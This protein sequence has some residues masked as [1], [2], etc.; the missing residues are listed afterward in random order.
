[1][2]QDALDARANGGLS[3]CEIVLA[4]YVERLTA[5]EPINVDAIRHDGTL[6]ETFTITK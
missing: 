3:R 5:G 4:G 2:A 1:M 6:I